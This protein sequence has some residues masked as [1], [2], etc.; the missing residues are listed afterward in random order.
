[1]LLLQ[2]D[3]KDKYII[4]ILKVTSMLPYDNSFI[5][6]TVCHMG[7]ISIPWILLTSNATGYQWGFPLIIT[8]NYRLRYICLFSISKPKVSG[9][10]WYKM[11]KFF[12]K[13]LR[14]IF[15]V[16]TDYGKSGRIIYE[17]NFRLPDRAYICNCMSI[18]CIFKILCT[19][20]R[21][22]NFII[23]SLFVNR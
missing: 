14:V 9:P 13:F 19:Q 20:N 23:S 11:L 2:S 10:D 1:M 18:F 22:I 12:Y 5:I 7:S 17:G 3:T 16:S 8:L 21:Y 15:P 4:K 6:L